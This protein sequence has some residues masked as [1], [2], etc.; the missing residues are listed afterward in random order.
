[1]EKIP[2]PIIT[3][4]NIE[5]LKKSFFAKSNTF[6]YILTASFWKLK[7][8]IVLVFITHSLN[9]PP[10]SILICLYES[11]PPCLV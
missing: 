2:I 1:M 3:P 11:L 10:A 7:E 8:N 4:F 6:K 9:I 5:S